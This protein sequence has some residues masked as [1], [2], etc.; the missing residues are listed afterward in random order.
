MMMLKV[1]LGK[2]Y[3]L[4]PEDVE[5]VYRALAAY[6]EGL[7]NTVSWIDK[8]DGTG[9]AIKNLKEETRHY[10]GLQMNIY[11]KAYGAKEQLSEP[12]ERVLIYDGEKT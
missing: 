11:D 12:V 9:T 6:A 5:M 10:R 1:R 7:D 4:Q 8:T 2:P 3:L